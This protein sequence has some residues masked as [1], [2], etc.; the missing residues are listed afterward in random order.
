MI[1]TLIDL[2]G[3]V[4]GTLDPDNFCKSRFYSFQ[5]VSPPWVFSGCMTI[6]VVIPSHDQKEN[7]VIRYSNG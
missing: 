2:L 4:T 1:R 6:A 3:E 5:S 7:P